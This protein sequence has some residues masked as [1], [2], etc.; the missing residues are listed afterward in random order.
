MAQNDDRRRLLADAAIEVLGASGG[1]GLTHRAVDAHAGVPVGTTVNYFASRAA[2]FT[3]IARRI[4][5]R[6]APQPEPLA[7]LADRDADLDTAVAYTRYVVE[8]LLAVP[9][10]ALALLELRLESARNPELAEE[11][12]RFVRAGLD[13][14]VAFNA[15]RGLPGE[16]ADIV[17]L[18]HAVNGV[19]LDRLTT[20]LEPDAD[21]LAVADELA[22]RI[23]AV[24]AAD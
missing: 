4:Y 15:G 16:R 17:L 22:R 20:P 14:D 8:R 23:L 3:G 1:R 10:L 5:T 21:P 6:I 13:D 2:L 19:V 18:H 9:T 11:L 12:A 24:A 7:T